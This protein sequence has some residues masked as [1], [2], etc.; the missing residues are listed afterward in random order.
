MSFLGVVIFFLILWVFWRLA[1]R[2]TPPRYNYRDWN[3]TTRKSLKKV[4][5][6]WENLDIS[7]L[8]GETYTDD[9]GYD[10][11]GDGRLVHRKV[12]HKHH[13]T[14]DKFS[15]GFREYVVHHKDKN[16]KNNSP[17]N[18]EIL[19]KEEHNKKHGKS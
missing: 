4:S 7:L 8:D 17:E 13:Y 2:E 10:R 3:Y 19:T 15:K 5:S 14:K 1:R 16:K 6:N 11:N 9:R 12:A 18:L